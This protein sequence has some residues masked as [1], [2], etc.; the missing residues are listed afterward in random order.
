MRG[1]LIDIDGVLWESDQVV[2]GAPEAVRWL[3]EQAIPHRFVT[4][5]T[6]R[7]RRLIV[8]KLQSLGIP[9]VAVVD[10]NCSLQ[11]IDYVIPGNDD[12][13]RAIALYLEVVAD[14]IIEARAAV[15]PVAVVTGDDDYIEVDEAGNVLEKNLAEPVAAATASTETAEAVEAQSRVYTGYYAQQTVRGSHQY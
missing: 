9:V 13:S 8:D 12:S 7:P 3:N 4:N 10:T 1:L 5:T 14:A 11:G 15:R 2:A 6:S